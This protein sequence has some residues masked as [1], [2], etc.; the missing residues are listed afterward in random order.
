MGKTKTDDQ[1]AAEPTTALATTGRTAAEC[2]DLLLPVPGDAP[3]AANPFAGVEGFDVATNMD[4]VESVVLPRIEIAHQAGVYQFADG[5]T[6]KAFEGRVI[7]TH[8]CN[9]LWFPDAEGAPEDEK[10]PPDC[11]SSDGLRPDSE[12][13]SD[14]EL[15]AGSRRCHQAATCAECAYN[16]YGSDLGGGRGKACKN[17]RRLALLLRGHRLPHILTLTP[18]SLRAWDDL[19][20][21]LSDRSIPYLAVVCSFALEV[22]ARGQEKFSRVLINA[23]SRVC[24]PV[25]APLI[26]AYRKEFAPLVQ[27]HKIDLGD[28]ASA[29]AAKEEKPF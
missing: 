15:E 8:R 22:V 13:A 29:D 21:S 16:A 23:D 11:S 2:N 19:V 1:P 24:D 4:G 10:R 25:D 17:M 28:Y 26:A 7:F 6:E 3:S 18:T 20:T 9:A 27:R 12:Q 5:E 14:A